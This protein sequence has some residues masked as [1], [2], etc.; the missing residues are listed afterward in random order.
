MPKVYSHASCSV[1]YYKLRSF[2]HAKLVAKRLNGTIPETISDTLSFY[3]VGSRIGTDT[4]DR[5]VDDPVVL[6]ESV[7]SA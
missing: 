7:P 3:A 5:V 6:R 1:Y 4:D 2:E